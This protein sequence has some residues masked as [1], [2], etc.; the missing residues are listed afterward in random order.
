MRQGDKRRG[1][2]ER[3]AV[4][5]LCVVAGVVGQA[6][7]APR[8]KTDRAKFTADTRIM[9]P[10]LAKPPTCDG[11]IAEGEWDGAAAFD[12]VIHEATLN[13]FPR[14]VRW[15][16]GWDE[17]HLY[18]A[19]RTS[20][21]TGEKP[22]QEIESDG[23]KNLGQDDSVALWLTRAD[24]RA[25][26][27]VIVSA[28]GKIYVDR[29]LGRGAEAGE[30]PNVQTAASLSKEAFDVEIVVPVADLGWK[31]GNRPGDRWVALLARNF[32]AG[33]SIQAPMPYG[34]ARSV[35]DTSRHPLLILGDQRPYVKVA[36]PREAL[37][38]GRPAAD[39]KVV[40]PSQ[41]PQDASVRLRVLEAGE[42][43]CDKQEKLTVPPGAASACRLEQPTSS[44]AAP[45]AESQRRYELTVTAADGTEIFHVHFPYSPGEGRKWLGKEM[46]GAQR[47]GQ[48][49]IVVD[50]SKGIP[51]KF[52]RHLG[53]YEDLPEGHKVHLTVRRIFE[54]SK[55][56][57]IDAPQVASAVDAKGQKDGEERY[58]STYG[59]RL[60]RTVTYK[61]GARH[62]PEK[63][64]G[65][66]YVKTEIPWQNGV[67]EGLRR[68]YHPN[69]QVMTEVRY[70]K[71]IPVG[72]GVSYDDQGRVIRVTEYADGLRSGSMTD[73]WPRKC[74]RIVPY[75][76][77]VINGVVREYY[78]NGNLKRERP[79]RS[80]ILHGV[81]RM[82]D[83]SGDKSKTK[84]RYWL[85]GD[86]V[87]VGEFKE[88]SGKPSPG[89]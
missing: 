60:L 13:F 55:R 15:H 34:F 47:H 70:E 57:E 35:H 51:F 25:R 23:D 82:Y 17:G 30:K 21:L 36:N 69:G 22:R 66:G 88:K 11:K 7:A 12:A 42:K 48:K 3:F 71:G 6:G 58:W 1:G 49:V 33:V 67:V 38:A 80:D 79:F 27:R 32:R 26:L 54:P 85:N 18:F 84:S 76:K 5:A 40:N 2:S 10:K 64:Y 14:S 81:E 37:Y 46:P 9:I 62:G 53:G 43:R 56:Y 52:Q 41:K 16:F 4:A 75:E 68:V 24:Q 78:E 44:P 28:A 86:L 89:K 31:R 73:Y 45:A 50:P 39:V 8:G 63:M 20:L 19:A 83:E 61:A 77:G 29:H 72:K 74:K 87:S 65:A 59:H